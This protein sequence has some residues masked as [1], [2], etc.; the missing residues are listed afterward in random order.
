MDKERTTL[1]I[2]YPGVSGAFSHQAAKALF[3][4]EEL[5][6]FTTFAEA[7]RAVSEGVCHKGVLPSENSYT[8]EVAEVSEILKKSSLYVNRTLDLT[9]RHNLLGIPG[10]T[11]SG[12]RQ[13]YSHPQAISQCA[14]WFRGKSIELV[15]S[16]NTAIAAKSVAEAGDPAKGAIASLETAELYGLSLIAE[17]IHT[18]KSNTTRFIVIS[19]DYTEEGDHFQLLFT[20]R[21]IP[22]QLAGVL[23]AVARRGFNMVNI[24][25]HA[26]ENEPWSYYFHVELMGNLADPAAKDM[27]AEIRDWCLEVKLLG[28]YYRT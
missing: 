26:I 27:I 10:A 12:I 23:T 5:I 11:L 7:A 20:V 4:G 8:G 15:A 2:A 25:S 14:D 28:G 13:V 16:P 17:N 3:P 18:S 19:R 22:G 1:K 6:P 21:N 9:V 24:K